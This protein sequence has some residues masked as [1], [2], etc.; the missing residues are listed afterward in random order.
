MI[1]HILSSKAESSEG[2]VFDSDGSIVTVDNS[3]NAHIFSEEEMLTNKIEP[4]VSI[5]V[6]TIGI[7]DI[8]EEEIGTVIWSWTDYEGYLNRKNSE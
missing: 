6:A 5:W 2:V 7:S 8:I 3:A 1:C 4:V